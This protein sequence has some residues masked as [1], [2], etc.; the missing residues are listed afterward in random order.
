MRNIR[1][2]L[3]QKQQQ[4]PCFKCESTGKRL[5]D[6]KSLVSDLQNHNCITDY[7][8]TTNHQVVV[9]HVAYSWFV[10][11]YS[12]KG[13]RIFEVRNN[14]YVDE[15]SDLFQ[16]VFDQINLNKFRHPSYQEEHA[17]EGFSENESK[18]LPIAVI[19]YQD[20]TA[21]ALAA[22]ALDFSQKTVYAKLLASALSVSLTPMF[23]PLGEAMFYQ[24]AA[25]SEFQ[26]DIETTLK[27]ILAWL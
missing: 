19:N 25:V 27:K 15:N 22:N 9:N 14:K 17:D 18:D 7:K 26:D 11:I 21:A 2:R 20:K 4:T 24:A 10:D 3:S 1:A 12:T 23:D 5:F 13:V 6:A 8:D 16:E